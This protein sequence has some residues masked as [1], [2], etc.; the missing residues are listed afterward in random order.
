[1][2]TSKSWKRRF[3][4]GINLNMRKSLTDTS[5]VTKLPS[6]ELQ[7]DETIIWSHGF[8]ADNNDII[9]WDQEGGYIFAST[10]PVPDPAETAET[11]KWKKYDFPGIRWATGAGGK[12]VGVSEV[13]FLSLVATKYQ[14]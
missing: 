9:L 11:W 6:K 13:N 2:A 10:V 7:G 8:S 12:V 14:G 3:S 4:Y 1:M 5:P